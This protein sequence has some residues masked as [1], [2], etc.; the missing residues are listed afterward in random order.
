M[1]AWLVAVS[2]SPWPT[3]RPELPDRYAVVCTLRIEGPLLPPAHA[4][5]TTGVASQWEPTESIDA[6]VPRA[7]ALLLP[8]TPDPWCMWLGLVHYEPPVTIPLVLFKNLIPFVETHRASRTAPVQ[9]E[10]WAELREQA[11]ARNPGLG[12]LFASLH[13]RLPWRQ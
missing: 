9:D 1:C 4:W 5:A 2:D 11:I 7:P 3:A 12:G 6:T 8:L 10:E 13:P